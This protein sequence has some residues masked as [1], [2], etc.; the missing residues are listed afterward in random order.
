[1]VYYFVLHC[2]M[3]ATIHHFFGMGGLKFQM[4][5]AALGL[6]WDEMVNYLEHY[7]LRRL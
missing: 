6:F 1:M 7:G 2:G 4:V 5:Y 3:A